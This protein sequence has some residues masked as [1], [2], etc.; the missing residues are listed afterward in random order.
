MGEDSPKKPPLLPY[1]SIVYPW[2]CDFNGHMNVAF[3]VGK[4]DEATFAFLDQL[5]LNS[6]DWLEAGKALV[7][8]NLEFEFHREV[9]SGD[10]IEVRTEVKK[11]GRS[12]LNFQHKL[13]SQGELAVSGHFTAVFM[14]QKKRKSAEIPAE[15]RQLIEAQLP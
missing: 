15:A 2:Q 8:R 9:F 14:D 11:L 4:M 5:G 13:F 12:S 6:K 3:I 7:A 1:R 10:I